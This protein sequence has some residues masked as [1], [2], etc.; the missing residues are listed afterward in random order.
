MGG[1][2]SQ[3]FDWI[4]TRSLDPISCLIWATWI[5]VANFSSPD[6]S[7]PIWSTVVLARGRGIDSLCPGLRPSQ[8]QLH[9]GFGVDQVASL[10]HHGGRIALQEG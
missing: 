7:S 5:C 9:A 2:R 10:F 8:S 4:L 6:M 1:A 3:H